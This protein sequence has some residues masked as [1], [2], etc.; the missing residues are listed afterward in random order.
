MSIPTATDGKQDTLGQE[1]E[2]VKYQCRLKY[3]ELIQ[4]G[5]INFADTAHIDHLPTFPAGAPLPAEVPVATGKDIQIVAQP[6]E[7]VSQNQPFEE[8]LKEDEIAKRVVLALAKSGRYNKDNRNIDSRWKEAFIEGSEK[9]SGKPK[10][11]T[12]RE[13]AAIQKVRKKCTS[14]GWN[15]ERVYKILVPHGDLDRL[16]GPEKS[17]H[18]NPT[19][20]PSE[21]Q[22]TQFPI[23]TKVR[24]IG[25]RRN[26]SLAASE[27]CDILYYIALGSVMCEGS[28]GNCTCQDGLMPIM[29][30]EVFPHDGPLQRVGG[31]TQDDLSTKVIEVNKPVRWHESLVRVAPEE[32]IRAKSIKKTSKSNKENTVRQSTRTRQISGIFREILNIRGKKNKYTPVAG[33]RGR[34]KN[35]GAKGPVIQAS[36]PETEVVERPGKRRTTKITIGK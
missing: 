20:E 6:A 24:L 10:V 15:F 22:H 30:Q 2:L 16:C 18:S 12:S 31:Q 29:V 32:N 13:A 7:S 3:L 34:K 33:K 28:R 14:K 11:T 5:K 4:E 8:W 19:K 17:K 26:I 35:G 25:K 36:K 27:E 21:R 9:I 23:A 1:V